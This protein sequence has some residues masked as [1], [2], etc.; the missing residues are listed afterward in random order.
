[1]GKNSF[2]PIPKVDSAVVEMVKENKYEIK[3]DDVFD[4]LISDAF[5]YKRKTIKNNLKGYDLNKLSLILDK[6]G[7]SLSDRAES[8]PVNVFI[9]MANVLS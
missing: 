1:M 9:E 3:D 7:Y 2:V 8:I 6:Y 5:Q 4:K